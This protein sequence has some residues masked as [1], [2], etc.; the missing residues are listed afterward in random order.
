MVSAR[1]NSRSV[2]SF[3]LAAASVLGL[4]LL[5]GLG[6]CIIDGGGGHGHYHGG[7]HGGHR[8]HCR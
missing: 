4:T 7:H 8:G 2:R 5:L 3:A 6:G 1:S